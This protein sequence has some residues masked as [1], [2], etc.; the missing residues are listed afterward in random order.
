MTGID[1][2]IRT[3]A[4]ATPFTL[5][6]ASTGKLFAWSRFLDSLDSFNLVQ[7]IVRAIAA[8]MI[9]AIEIV[10]LAMLLSGR[11]RTA[12]AIAASFVVAVSMVVLAQRLHRAPPRLRLL[13]SLVGLLGLEGKHSQHAH[14]QRRARGSRGRRFAAG[15]VVLKPTRRAIPARAW[16]L[17]EVL[18]VLLVIALLA[19]ILAPALARSL[20]LSRHAKSLS[21]LRTHAAAFAAYTADHA[22]AYPLFTR[23]TY[24]WGPL[25][26]GGI[27]IDALAYFDAHR[28]WHVALT[29]TYFN[30]P[31]RA[32]LFRPPDWEHA[33]R[34]GLWPSHTPYHYPCV[35]IAD[36]MYWNPMSRRG[37]AQYRAIRDAEVACPSAKSLVV[38]NPVPDDA[39]RVAVDARIRAAWCD[40]YLFV[41]DG[42]IHYTDLPRMLHTTDGVRGRDRR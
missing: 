19:A 37:P 8:P 2:M 35:F 36:P 27:R 9:P 15:E 7:P 4:A 17:V 31:A 25:E 18:I 34:T 33:P 12:N 24:S 13:R 32:E 26:G 20:G 1:R 23:P 39:G 29:D 42:A 11:R 21:N 40:G 6:V 10:P 16:T 41:N 28:T 3:L 30:L 22:G 38:E 14:P 5:A